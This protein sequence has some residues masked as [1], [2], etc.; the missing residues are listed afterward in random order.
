MIA[1]TEFPCISEAAF[2]VKVDV[3]LE[4]ERTRTEFCRL[5]KRIVEQFFAVAL[6]L[7]LGRNAYRSHCH[8]RDIPA[9]VCSDERPH[10]HILTDELSVLFHNKVKLGDESRIV[11]QLMK[12]I[13]FHTAG[14]V[15][16]P[17]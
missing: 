1:D 9:V 15:D 8:Y 17:E 10:K 6:A 7:E 5:F 12:Q 11:S 2:A 14:A 4:A 3:P 16:V 13:M